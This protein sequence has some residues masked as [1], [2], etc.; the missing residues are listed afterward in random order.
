[1]LLV[2]E[3]CRGKSQNQPTSTR[4]YSNISN[5]KASPTETG[6]NGTYGA[7]TLIAE[8][9]RQS[10]L[11][12]PQQPPKPKAAPT[13]VSSGHQPDDRN[14]A[15]GLVATVRQGHAKHSTH[16]ERDYTPPASPQ[17][18]SPENMTL[19]SSRREL[20]TTQ[21]EENELHFHRRQTEQNLVTTGKTN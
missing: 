14:S 16:D 9:W 11:P 15:D 12:T 20:G 1:M 17:K 19:T 3:Q 2:R 8:R 10:G 5:G 7:S 4:V 21:L 18:G 13:T 6:S